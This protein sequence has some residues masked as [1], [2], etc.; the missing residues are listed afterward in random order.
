MRISSSIGYTL[1]LLP[2]LF[3]AQT[4]FAQKGDK[5]ITPEDIFKKNTFA[6]KSV[7]GFNA[8]KDGLRFTKLEGKDKK[9]TIDVYELKTG[10]K[11]GTLF[12]SKNDKADGKEIAVAAYE[13]SEDETKMLL[14][15]EPE[16]I[17]R[18]SV[19]YKTYV[20]DRKAS[21]IEPLSDDKVLH[22]QLSPDGNKVAYVHKNNLY[23]K[24][25]AT[26]K[27]EYITKDGEWNKIING[28][29]DWVYEEEFGFTQ[30]YQWSPDG[31]Y[32][33]YYRFDE[34]KVREYVMTKYNGLY[35]ENYTYKYP[36]AGEDN[37]VVE[38]HIFNTEN[39]TDVTVN[40]GR[41]TDQYIPRIKWT[42]DP[43]KLCVWRLNRLQNHLELL[44]ADATDGTSKVI[45]EEANKYYVDINDNTEFLPDGRSMILSSERDGY[46]HLY[47]Y[48]WKNNMLIDL[49][50][51]RYDIEDL[52]GVDVNRKL[53]Y[54]TSAE[55]SPLE[56]NL[57]AVSWN[58]RN[59]EL[60]TKEKGTHQV[61]KIEGF[62]YFLDKYSTLNGA[63][64]FTLRDNKGNIVRT[65]E[66]NLKLTLELEKYALGKLEFM[67]IKGAYGDDLNA[68][69]IT[70]PDFDAKKKYPVLM[71]Q[72]SGPNS[73]QVSDR[74]P[75]K[76]YFWHQMLAQKGYI[77]VCADGTGTGFRGEEFRKKTYLQLGN[78]ES[79]DQ[80][81]IAQ[82]LGKLPYVDKDRIGIWGWSYGGFMSSTCLFKGKGVFK[83]AIA[84]APV[85]NWR[86]YD[87][88]YTERYMRTP[89][90]NVGGYDDNSPINMVKDMQGKF[91][92]IHGT[93][94]DNVHFQNSVVLT[95]ALIQ[96]NKEFESEYYPDKAHG[97]SGGNTRYHLYNRMTNFILN[98]L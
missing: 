23:Y 45:Y 76:D 88:I 59:K 43:K 96:A 58:G 22:A 42:K 46:A 70:P 27:T 55:K 63:P 82:N 9:Q 53:V 48:D 51:G 95:E 5:L 31:K 57:Y 35:P 90:E 30:A 18:H 83:M 77:V 7:P 1:L 34:S 98:N 14:K 6:I 37:S 72:Y 36:K 8:M 15:S 38:I 97:I 94:D 66:D 52:V 4:A 91:L 80:I 20:F 84:V 68:W 62:H 10:N 73:Q 2:A 93:G 67:T 39:K 81:A 86:Y 3:L 85:T 40:V 56:R 12:S 28:N 41:E 87:N 24:D 60:L 71:F 13:F 74:F 26:G 44:L 78:M 64:I 50:R 79:E 69:M 33:A 92:L 89:K 29:C 47:H 25:L 21:K 32:I 61:T 65:L 49:T 11:L 16:N 54:Y 19:L 17:Y 75:A